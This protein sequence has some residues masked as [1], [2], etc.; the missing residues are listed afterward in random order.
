MTRTIIEKGE[1]YIRIET[2]GCIISIKPGHLKKVGKFMT[3]CPYCDTEGQ[4]SI[5]GGHFNAQGMILMA[6]GFTFLDAKVLDTDNEWVSCANCE[7]VFPL[8]EVTIDDKEIQQ[9]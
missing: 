2:D 7:R 4:L 1:D 3:K 9:P 5:S 8:K 6:E